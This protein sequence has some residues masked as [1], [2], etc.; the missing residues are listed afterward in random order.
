MIARHLG[1]RVHTWITHN[2]PW[3]ISLL[4]RHRNGEH[5]GLA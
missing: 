3:C 4:S 1:D 5:A 2:E